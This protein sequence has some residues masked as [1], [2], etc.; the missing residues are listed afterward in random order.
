MSPEHKN[1]LQQ[2]W[3]TQRF[4][5]SA[6]F[7]G[8]PLRTS[9]Y[10]LRRWARRSQARIEPATK[11]TAKPMTAEIHPVFR[12]AV[13][14]RIAVT[15]IDLL[16]RDADRQ[17]EGNYRLAGGAYRHL[18]GSRAAD[19]EDQEDR[20]SYHRLYWA[21]RYA[22]AAAFGHAAATP[23]LYRELTAWLGSSGSA[24]DDAGAAYSVAERIASLAE[25]LF[26]TAT[27]AP[28]EFAARIPAK[29]VASVKERIWIDASLLSANIEHRLGVHNHLLN[30]ARALYTAAAVLPECT[31]A[32][33]WKRLAFELW[34]HYFP[35]LVLSD[36]AFA[37]QSSHYHL[38]LCRTGLE[39]GLA[40]RQSGRAV[41]EGFPEKLRAM[42][43]LAN[44]LF[45]PNGSLPRFG[46]NSPDCTAEDLW[47]LLA[48]A[49]SHG[50]LEEPPRHAVVTPLTIYY[51]G[52][53]VVAA[54]G[55]LR[56]RL[57]PEGGF[58][59]LGPADGSAELAVH[60]DP[61][62]EITAHGDAGRGSFELWRR[63]QVIIREPG[64]FLRPGDS[65]GD[66]YRSA[67]AQNVT[68]IDG[69]GPAVSRDD[70]RRLPEWYW[71][72]RGAWTQLPEGSVRFECGAFR[73]LRED[74][75]VVR[76]WSCDEKEMRFEERLSGSG[77]VRFVSRVFLGEGAWGP[78]CDLGGGAWQ[79]DSS[80][81]EGRSARLVVNAPDRVT[82]A[83]ENA[84]FTPEYGVER[85]ARVISLKGMPNL[86]LRW[87]LRCE[88]TS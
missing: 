61:R 1:Y 52:S 59:F 64:C 17:L 14:Q 35:L 42:F 20:H 28:A 43:S 71:K 46:D 29:F 32:A 60:A 10:R 4:G 6:R 75:E 69:L 37:E 27:E 30:N 7:L 13:P 44:D 47:G 54:S 34:D 66:W 81:G 9:F 67:E 58:A 62:A 33:D 48:A 19:L 77:A 79:I 78:L 86:P 40:A 24:G 3:K 56:T 26:W 22:R 50:F 85:P 16:F 5:D 74:R 57:Y 87:T 53:S 76:T 2:C 88:F 21:A 82:V 23:A 80:C 25:V 63:G 55:H 65:R 39:Y 18:D 31:E 51:G 12:D 83:I 72:N 68:C 15:G 84:S 8:R 36:G 49:R 73:R 45:R 70:Q 11:V 41:P 38:L